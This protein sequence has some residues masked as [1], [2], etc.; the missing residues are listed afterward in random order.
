[1]S[2]LLERLSPKTRLILGILGGLISFGLYNI[3]DEKN[4]GV[5]LN[6]SFGFIVAF[7]FLMLVSYKFNVLIK[8]R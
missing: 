7:S 2:S 4:T 8:R 6:F 5:F 3:I 1:M